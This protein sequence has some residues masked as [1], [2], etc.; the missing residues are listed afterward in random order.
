M[1]DKAQRKL[2]TYIRKINK[3]LAQDDFLG[4]GRFSVHQIERHFYDYERLYL[5]QFVDNKTGATFEQYA[6]NYNFLRVLY[7]DLN[8][9]IIEIRQKEHW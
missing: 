2:N 1:A 6:N 9:F 3:S 8:N 5:L 4:R 7:R